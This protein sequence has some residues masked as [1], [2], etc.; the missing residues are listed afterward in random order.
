MKLTSHLLYGCW[1]LLY[2][3]LVFYF[4]QCS[5][6]FNCRTFW[7]L[8]FIM[9]VYVYKIYGWGPSREDCF[10]HFLIYVVVI[11]S[12]VPEHLEYDVYSFLTSLA[13]F[14]LDYAVKHIYQ[15]NANKDVQLP[16]DQ[17]WPASK[18]V[19]CIAIHIWF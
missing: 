10:V 18:T 6:H 19:S 17:V 15:L 9:S 5:Y 14:F 8:C 11:Y 1:F 4:I 3:I 13:S 2:F 16:N 7:R 12:I